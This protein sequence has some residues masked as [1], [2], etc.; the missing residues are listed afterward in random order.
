MPLF[1]YLAKDEQGNTVTD[2]IEAKDE[3]VALDMLR[4]KNY[5]I[6]SIT[7]EKKGKPPAAFKNKKVKA[8]EL[9]IFS[10]QLATMVNAGIPLVQSLDILSEQMESPVFRGVVSTI[11][12]DVES[13]ASLSG[14]LEKHP[15]VF[16]VLYAN[17]VKAGETSGML[18]EILERLAGYLEKNEQL[19][20]KVK[21][22]MIYPLVVSLMA[23]GITLVLLLKVIPTFKEIFA[24]LGGTL[25]LPTQILIGISDTL[26]QYFIYAVGVIGLVGFGVGRLIQ[27]PK[28]RAKFDQIKLNLPVFGALLRKVAVARFSRTLSTLIRSGVPILGALEIVGKT[29][30][31]V[32]IE[33][34]VEKARIG[35]REGESISQPLVKS[36]AFPPMVTRMISVGEE[37][38]ELEKM[39]SKIA[40]F[41]EDQVDAAVSGLTSLIEPLIIAFLGIVVG[42]IV[43]AMFLPIFKITELIG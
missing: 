21:S 17:M 27:T 19:Q 39:L 14:A 23:V 5:I 42:S 37:S 20:R 10:R 41:Y 38:G 22:A 15:K 3:A 40:D 6:I 8:E 18:D 35:I 16:S 2:L 1:K 25:P 31:N 32:V 29:A 36:K 12:G 33:A 7:E 4:V 34:A 24:T 43:I 26:R 9:V 11:R 30:G 28:G 13:G